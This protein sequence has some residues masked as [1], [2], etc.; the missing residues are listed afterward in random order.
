[1]SSQSKSSS[2]LLAPELLFV[3]D[4]LS[5][6]LP[7]LIIINK[8]LKENRHFKAKVIIS[9]QWLTDLP[10]GARNNVDY[11]LLFAQIP[12]DKLEQTYQDLALTVSFPVFLRMYYDATS[13]L[14]NFLYVDAIES[15]FRKNF[16][17]EY[18]IES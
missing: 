17:Q 12:E 13:T 8:L 1:M 2:G 9:T 14:H 18:E 4:D 16:D 6:E 5:E 3:F 7:H 10:K 11:A 15:K